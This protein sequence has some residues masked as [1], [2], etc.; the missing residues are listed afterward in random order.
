MIHLQRNPLLKQK[1]SNYSIYQSIAI[2]KLLCACMLCM[3][4]LC[5]VL[6]W[7]RLM[8]CGGK[9][10]LTKQ[11]GGFKWRGRETYGYDPSKHSNSL[12][13]Y[14]STCACQMSTIKIHKIDALF[15]VIQLLLVIIN[16]FHTTGLFL[17]SLK[18]SK[19]LWFPD[20]FRRY[21]KKPVAWYGLKKLLMKV[22][23]VM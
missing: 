9:N 8:G 3:W 14:K 11:T 6:D 16:S 18:T 13:L 7:W 5:W 20:A 1:L 22:L 19:N 17:Y 23:K 2:I 10:F 15:E 12:H 21:N 4:M